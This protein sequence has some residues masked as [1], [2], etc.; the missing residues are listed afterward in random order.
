MNEAGGTPS[1]F[2]VDAAAGQSQGAIWMGG[3]APA[4][5]SAGNVWVTVG[6]GSVTTAGQPYDNSDG[7]L[8]LSPSLQ[9]LQYFA[10]A[11][12][13]QDNADDRDLSME[14]ALLANGQVVVSGKSRIIDLLNGAH[15]GGIGGEASMLASGCAQNVDGGSAVMG[16]T[17]YLPCLSGP[18]AVQVGASPPS[19]N[20][21]WRATVGGGPPIVAA[22]RVWTIGQDGTLYGLDPTTGEVLQQAGIGVPAN[23]FPTPERWRRPLARR[24]G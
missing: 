8:E 16:S 6:N 12:W 24:F 11:T 5:D 15:L 7:A 4:V 3:A 17:V 1:F 9:L 18:I 22:G 10:P 14:P 19:L 23:H 2:T 13:A 20:V 21:L